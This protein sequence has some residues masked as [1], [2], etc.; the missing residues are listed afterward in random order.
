MP[1]YDSQ[2]L[3]RI[4]YSRRKSAVYYPDINVYKMNPVQYTN[5]WQQLSSHKYLYTNGYEIKAVGWFTWVFES[6]RSWLF[7]LENHCHPKKIAY[8]LNKLVYYGYTQGYQ[9]PDFSGLG[10]YAPSLTIQ[11]LASKP[12]SD[13]ST[14]QLQIALIKEYFSCEP[15]L[16]KQ[17]YAKSLPS[18]H[19]F[20]LSW[21]YLNAAELAPNTNPQNDNAIHTIIK[22]LDAPHFANTTV[23]FIENSKYAKAAAQFYC[24]K[25]KSVQLP[26]FIYRL[27][28]TD[29]RPALLSHALIYDPT[30]ATQEA[31][32]FIDY[33]L[34]QKE[35]QSAVPLLELLPESP[36]VLKKI[37]TIP[38]KERMRLVRK[39][40]C[41]AQALAKYHIKN[42]D[43]SLAQELCS[44]IERI[45]PIAA[46]IIAF[47]QGAYK[48]AYELFTKQTTL[49][50]PSSQTKKL[51]NIFSELAE[52]EYDKGK[53]LR[54]QGDLLAAQ[55]YYLQS[56]YYK[57]AASTLVPSKE[58]LEERSTHTRLYAQLILDIDIKAWRVEE[59]NL[60][61][62]I[63][64][65]TL[66]SQ[67]RPSSPNEKQYHK[68]ALAKALMRKIDC[69]KQ[70][71]CVPFQEHHSYSTMIKE[72]GVHIT[73]FIAALK[74][75]IALTQH[76]RSNRYSI[77]RG[78]AHFLL[79]DVQLH[80]GINA[81]D[82]NHHYRQAME[83]VPNNAFYILRCSE[84]FPLE[85]DHLQCRGIPKFKA[86]GFEMMDY[87]HW[88]E[89][90]WVKQDKII[91][92]IKDIHY[93]PEKQT[94]P[95][96][97]SF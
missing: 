45:D 6:I 87:L 43:Y 7:S 90:R 89:E 22:A 96:T 66:L 77:M 60:S 11:T 73:P 4:I 21:V 37:L 76:D 94:Q 82:I 9:Q 85:R 1:Y 25:A 51:S 30:I 58:N 18:N 8:T 67:C 70:R 38:Q 31:E 91:Y 83:S 13:T 5:L 41:L 92:D 24:N 62:V 44:N 53:E 54:I 48:H 80:F 29:P 20:G 16:L 36:L 10:E 42:K 79:A 14:Q 47:N 86:L 93:A 72:K 69:L 40:G 46:F 61:S 97:F 12:Y 95:K 23:R 81:P 55:P 49:T 65:I 71:I 78:K 68:K 39:D 88:W 35:Y 28:W 3:S 84:L 34:S 59:S 64:A 32:I 26:N 19:T 50:F 52:K 2:L 15:Q 75:L 56:L 63:K 57:T 74:D 27:M 17:E 33:H